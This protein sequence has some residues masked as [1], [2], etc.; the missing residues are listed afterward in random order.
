MSGSLKRPIFPLIS[1]AHESLFS[2]LPRLKSFLNRPVVA[3][4]C[5]RSVPCMLDRE[6]MRAEEV[7][8]LVEEVLERDDGDG[9][10]GGDMAG[11]NM[12]P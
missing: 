9:E 12:D 6:E 8:V 5:V 7:E 2:S 11:L 10:V 4:L 1:A 3:D